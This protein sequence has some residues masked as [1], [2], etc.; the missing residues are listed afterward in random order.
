MSKTINSS[1][2]RL[3]VCD[4]AWR[5]IV[6]EG[7]NNASMRAIAQ[8]LGTTTGFVTH[9]FR[10]KD[11]LMLYALNRVIEN[12]IDSMHNC[13]KGSQG[14]ERF[15]RMMLSPL[16]L[17]LG[18]EIG[19]KIWI[20]FLGYAIGCEDLIEEHQRRYTELHKIIFKELRDLQTAKLIRQEID[21]N[22]EA[23]AII[24][25]IDGIGTGFVINPANYLPD[26]QRYLVQRYINSLL[27]E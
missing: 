20:A 19:W 2:R 25:F 17:E 13:M 1:N 22:N 8:E 16:P 3:E 6:R 26:Q 5:A 9:Y 14:L 24:A 12:T 18:D 10:N 27:K 7:L 21:L 11:E 15:E 23:N 4:A